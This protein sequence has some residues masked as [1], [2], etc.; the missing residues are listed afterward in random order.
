[1]QDSQIGQ[2]FVC[3]LLYSRDTGK[4]ISAKWV[5]SFGSASLK[6]ILLSE[7]LEQ[8]RVFLYDNNID[9]IKSD[10]NRLFGR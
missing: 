4:S 10:K 1:M 2:R 7:L 3:L 5:E 9:L 6:L 8:P